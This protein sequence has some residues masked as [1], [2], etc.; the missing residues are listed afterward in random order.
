MDRND[1]MALIVLICFVINGSHNPEVAVYVTAGPR[2]PGAVRLRHC[3]R[4][5]NQNL[6]LDLIATVLYHSSSFSGLSC[7]SQVVLDFHDS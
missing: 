4:V 1:E 2:C 3:A 7:I 5:I 6:S